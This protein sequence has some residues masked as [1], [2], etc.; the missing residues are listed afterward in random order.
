MAKQLAVTKTKM[1]EE[2]I[3]WLILS[4]TAAAFFSMAAVMT[5]PFPFLVFM[6]HHYDVGKPTDAAF[7]AGIMA[8]AFFLGG[9]LLSYSTPCLNH[10]NTY[11]NNW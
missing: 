10:T 7:Y 8:S 2:P 9:G 5:L 1:D 3:P 4:V 11:T 6:I